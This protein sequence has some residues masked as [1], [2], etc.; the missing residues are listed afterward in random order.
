MIGQCEKTRQLWHSRSETFQTKTQRFLPYMLAALFA[1]FLAAL[2]VSAQSANENG[3]L[4]IHVSPKQAYVFVDGKAIRDGSQTI[5]LAPGKHSVAVE[6]YGY[7]PQ[8]QEVEITA[9]STAHLDVAL[10]ASGANVSGPFGDIEFK[11][12]PRAAVLLNGTTRAYFVGHVDEFD[13]DWIWHQRL[14]VH[15]GT[16]QV[17]VMREGNTI[18]SGPITV[19][20]GQKVVVDLNH[21][22]ETKTV[23]WPQ[24]NS[25]GP[26]PR[27]HAGVASA[28]VPIAP[29]TARL[30]A[31]SSQL[32]CGQSTDLNW[33]SAD[34]IDVSITDLGKVA[35]SGDRSVTPAK[36]TNYELVAKGPG[37]EAVQTATVNVNTQPTATLTLN[38]PTAHFHQVGD[39]IVQDDT[40]TLN[41]TTSNA[42]KVTIAPL[43][44]EAP[45]GSQTVAAKP[46]QTNIG[47]VNETYGYTLVGSNACGGRVKQTAL[48]HIVGSIDPPPPVT[49]ASL[50]YPTNYPTNRHPR[51]GLVGTEKATLSDIARRFLNHEQYEQKASLMIVGHADVRGAKKYN[52]T[53]SERRVEL[54]K[55]YLVSQ[56]VPSNKIQTRAV[57]KEQE[58]SVKQVN[59]LQAQDTQK[60]EK[61]M[62]HR[63]KETW[64]AYNRRVDVLLEPSG[65]QSIEAY[66]NDAT[67]ARILW[68]RPEPSLKAVELAGKTSSGTKEAQALGPGH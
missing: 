35:A 39:K 20:A 34:A 51:I 16:F 37:G 31:Q 12:F 63:A 55:D 68:Q 13:W 25:M 59:Q 2:P 3:K 65:Q 26:Q 66:P 29:V 21:N 32:N 17:T 4:R 50:F 7:T 30:S 22:G 33:N 1:V 40:T 52:L 58:L 67:D 56:G 44:E 38:Q 24:G 18:W 15:P 62:M 14:M 43:G 48:L 45:N 10:E 47:L 19:K 23:D 64:L 9:G 5:T 36:T 54:V 61:W 42:D 28:T 60:P 6:N 41:W 46:K 27:F 8:T 57:G 53:L 11:G 49:L